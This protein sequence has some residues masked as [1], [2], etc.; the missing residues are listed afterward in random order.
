MKKLFVIIK[1][2]LL[3]YFI[4][5]LAYV[6]LIAFLLLNGSFAI[7]FGSFFERGSADLSSMFAFQPWLY[8]LFLPGISMRLWSEEFRSKTIV[9]IMTM[10]VSTSTYVWGKFF[11]SWL[12]CALALILTFPFWITVNILGSPD[13][14]IITLSYIGSF[15]LA[16][17]MLAISQT[18]S[19]LTKNQVI[20][21]VLSVVV[22]LIFFLSGLEYVLSF[23]R[24][25]LPLSAVDMIAS[26]SFL[27]HFD[28]II[29]GLIELRD[30]IFFASIILLFNFTNAIGSACAIFLFLCLIFS[31]LNCTRDGRNRTNT[32]LINR[33]IIRINYAKYILFYTLLY[34]PSL[35]L[36]FCQTK[37]RCT[38]DANRHLHGSD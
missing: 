36:S 37:D 32:L 23:V 1:N 8:L 38:I 24:L 31:R 12:F 15:I 29:N 4:S 22:N 16:G 19:A 20:A 28:T 27:T 5:P 35:H 6:Y 21:L 26:F 11:A 10:P 14:G 7:Y 9:Q 30:I 33:F 34:T 3:R 13:N 2:E 17:C 18:M 25:F